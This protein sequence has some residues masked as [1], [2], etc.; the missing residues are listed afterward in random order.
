MTEHFPEAGE[1]EIRKILGIRYP[2][3][4]RKTKASTSAVKKKAAEKRVR[5]Y[6]VAGWSSTFIGTTLIGGIQ[7]ISLG[8]IGE[9]VGKIYME[10]KRR[11][12]YTVEEKK[13]FDKNKQL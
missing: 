1:A 4:D 10:T 12:R 9:Y 6:V 3:E 13:G 2:G 5:S 11:P 7:L 8:V